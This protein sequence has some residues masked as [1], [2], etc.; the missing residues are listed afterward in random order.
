MIHSL[1]RRLSLIFDRP[2]AGET[3]E[4]VAAH[5]EAAVFYPMVDFV[6]HAEDGILSGRLRLSAERLTDMLND[7]AELHLVDVVVQSLDEPGAVEV[8]EL[9]VQRDE[10]LLVHA[11]GPRGNQARRT[12]TR[13]TY[14]A[15]TSGPY[16]VQ[17]Y[18][19]GTPGLDAVAG[20]HRRSAMVPLTD[21]VVDYPIGGQ[22]RRQHLG[23]IVNRAGIDFIVPALEH[24]GVVPEMALP[25]ETGSLP[26]DFAGIILARSTRSSP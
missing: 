2:S 25:L 6:A 15:I 12:R 16:Q 21:A 10:L 4:P 18:L 26:T 5:P 3:G 19:H 17:G 11:T 7:H 22:L 1:G 9:L 23:I 13:Q 24:H 8:K 20:L 14:V